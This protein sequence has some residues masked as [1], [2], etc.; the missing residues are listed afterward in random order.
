MVNTNQVYNMIEVVD[1]LCKRWAHIV[2]LLFVFFMD[3]KVGIKIT[4]I[5]FQQGVFFL[6]VL[7]DEGI[8][9]FAEAAVN[10]SR[11][12]IQVDD[13]IVFSYHPDLIICQ[14]S[15]NRTECICTTV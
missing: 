9:F 2:H 5:D 8:V 6:L 14:V 3:Q 13:A 10:K 12:K 15:G 11:I 4:W 7:S 1:E